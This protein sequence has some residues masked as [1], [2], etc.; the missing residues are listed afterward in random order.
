MRNPFIKMFY[1]MKNGTMYELQYFENYG[2]GMLTKMLPVCDNVYE[3]VDQ[4]N[5]SGKAFMDT[6]A[7]FDELKN[8]KTYI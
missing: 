6:K 5:I 2:H 3:V 1:T 4:H 7:A 8:G